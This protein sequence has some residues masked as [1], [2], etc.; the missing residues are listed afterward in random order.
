MCVPQSGRLVG[1]PSGQRG[2]TV[3]LLA[4]PSMVRIHHLPPPSLQRF[5]RL[6]VSKS[7][8]ILAVYQIADFL[9]FLIFPW[10]LFRS[11]QAR[12]PAGFCFFEFELQAGELPGARTPP[13]E[14]AGTPEAVKPIR[15]RKISSARAIQ[16]FD[17]HLVPFEERQGPGWIIKGQSRL[18]GGRQ[19]VRPHVIEQFL[20]L[21][22]HI[23]I[24]L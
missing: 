2:Q 5:K 23:G 7:E 8:P 9:G 6:F 1:Y 13:G 15:S 14:S 19:M 21:R 11:F 17:H 20:L 10:R 16:Q 4:M 18:A 12:R 22:C 3:N 24:F